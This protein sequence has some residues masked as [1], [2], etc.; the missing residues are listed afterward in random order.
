MC[1]LSG[2]SA[3]LKFCRQSSDSKHTHTLMEGI[4]RCVSP[5][6]VE[7]KRMNDMWEVQQLLMNLMSFWTLAK[8]LNVSALFSIYKFVTSQRTVLPNHL[9]RMAWFVFLLAFFLKKWKKK[10]DLDRYF[11]RLSMFDL[12]WIVREFLNHISPVCSYLG[13][14][15]TFSEAQSLWC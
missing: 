10:Y 14:V 11:K 9:L 3:A 1:K 13:Q 15:L 4:D 6:M 8:Y 2:D 7:L 12:I 5:L